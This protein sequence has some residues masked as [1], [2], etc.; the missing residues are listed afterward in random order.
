[1]YT[2]LITAA[3]AGME[4]QSPFKAF[5]IGMGLMVSFGLGTIPSLLLVAGL[6]DMKWLRS[7][8]VIYKIGSVLMI[9][10]GIYFA[11]K[12]IRY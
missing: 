3:R 6:T 8:E 11:I 12:G 5:F 9:A 10:V 4:I 2:A 7:R 1:V